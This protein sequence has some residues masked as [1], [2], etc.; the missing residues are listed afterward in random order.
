MTKPNSEIVFDTRFSLP[1]ISVSL[2]VIGSVRYIRGTRLTCYSGDTDVTSLNICTNIPDR[3][4]RPLPIP[5]YRQKICP[6]PYRFL[7]LHIS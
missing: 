4:P 2:E 5:R 3:F 1:F 6:L 7:C